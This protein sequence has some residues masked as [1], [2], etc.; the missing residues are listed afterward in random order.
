M[1]QKL[2]AVCYHCDRLLEDT[3]EFMAMAFCPVCIDWFSAEFCREETGAKHLLK[4]PID[5]SD[6]EYLSAL[7]VAQGYSAS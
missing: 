3:S 4:E 6:T 5:L 7:A 1:S 2:N